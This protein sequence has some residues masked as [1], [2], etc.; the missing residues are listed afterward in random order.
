M[1]VRSNYP[2]E[3]KFPMTIEEAH[4]RLNRALGQLFAND[5]ILFELDVN[6][7]TLT[8]K[9]AE[10]LQQAFPEYNV[11]CEYNRNHRNIK[12]LILP[13]NLNPWD[14]TEARTVFPDVIVHR[15]GTNT[16]VLVIE[17]KK[18]SSGDEAFDLQ[19]LRA[20]RDELGYEHAVF[21]RFRTGEPNPGAQVRFL[22][23]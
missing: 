3:V 23:E 17:A 2:N 8:H 18:T 5:G 4:A 20:F 22:N 12:T 15:R 19:K 21:L 7:R 16:N 10:Y 11:D 1:K 9:L 14:D 13:N 6:E